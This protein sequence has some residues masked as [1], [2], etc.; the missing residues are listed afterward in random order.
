MAQ[1]QGVL[2]KGGEEKIG[3]RD[4][5]PLGVIQCVMKKGQE[6]GGGSKGQVWRALSRFTIVIQRPLQLKQNKKRSTDDVFIHRNPCVF[7]VIAVIYLLGYIDNDILCMV[8]T[9]DV[10]TRPQES[11]IISFSPVLLCVRVKEDADGSEG[12]S[13]KIVWLSLLPNTFMR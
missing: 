11:L 1:P 10:S 2:L 9:L 4:S 3:F 7:S 12:G 13:Y 6:N 5:K 8:C